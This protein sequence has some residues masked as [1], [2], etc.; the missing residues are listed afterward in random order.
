MRRYENLIA[1][2]DKWSIIDAAQSDKVLQ[3]VINNLKIPKDAKITVKGAKNVISQAKG[4]N[5]TASEFAA[6]R[7]ANDHGLARGGRDWIPDVFA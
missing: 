7:H 5:Q 3:K 1:L 6:Q 2:P 4:K